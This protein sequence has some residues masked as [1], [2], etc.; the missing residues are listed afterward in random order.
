MVPKPHFEELL[1]SSQGTR[2]SGH[3]GCRQAHFSRAGLLATESGGRRCADF[4]HPEISHDG[5]GRRS[6]RFRNH[7]GW[8]RRSDALRQNSSRAETGRNAQL[9]NV[10]KVD[11]SLV[12]PR[13]EL[14]SC[15]ARYAPEQLRVLSVT[16]GITD[17][18]SIRYRHEEKLLEGSNDP[19][20]LYHRLVLP[21][22]ADPEP[23]VYRPDVARF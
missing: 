20:E 23:R 12:G 17:I 6:A 8:G 11:M 10:L 13:P 19:D 16:P 21:H 14:P 22:K 5:G 15:V 1:T 3:C 2:V 9:W 18:A 7:H 4:S